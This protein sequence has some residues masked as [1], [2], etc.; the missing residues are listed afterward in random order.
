MGHN[1]WFCKKRKCG[2][3]RDKQ[4]TKVISHMSGSNSLTKLIKV[5]DETYDRL[6]KHCKIKETFDNLLN[7]ASG[8]NVAA[9]SAAWGR[10]SNTF[11]ITLTV[12]ASTFVFFT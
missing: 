3:C 8:V 9:V 6:L 7:G 12:F 2:F 1:K 11:C 10:T 5:R 4:H